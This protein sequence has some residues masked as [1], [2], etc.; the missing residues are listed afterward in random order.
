MM[1]GP[2]S[3]ENVVQHRLERANQDIQTANDSARAAIQAAILINGGA[4]TAILAYLSKGTQTPTSIIHAA[5]W[6]LAGYA[7]G[8]ACAAASMWLQTQAL[9]QF[10]HHHETV[11]REELAKDE[12]AKKRLAWEAQRFLNRGNRWLYGHRIWFVLSVA[13]FVVS[14]LGIAREFFRAAP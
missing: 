2:G 11:A 13:V 3:P 1:N 8:V 14:S 7:V 4:A 9:A 5:S 6:A 10:A 12:S